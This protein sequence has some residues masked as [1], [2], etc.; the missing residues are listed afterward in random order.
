MGLN[1]YGNIIIGVPVAREDFFI[2]M[3][4]SYGCKNGHVKIKKTGKLAV[5]FCDQCGSE[6]CLKPIEKPTSEFK[7]WAD[8][9]EI[10]ADDLWHSLRDQYPYGSDSDSSGIFCID[11]ISS[12]ENG[13]S[14]LAL[15]FRVAQTSDACHG[16][17][18][19]ILPISPEFILVKIEDAESIARSVGID[20]KAQVF[21]T[22]HMSY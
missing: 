15:G 1:V 2:E 16:C 8:E 22:V 6:L 11:S 7:A 21:L 14:N 9:L 10:S 12:S 18:N 13:S 5:K 19:S 3:G 17:G 20:R 4:S